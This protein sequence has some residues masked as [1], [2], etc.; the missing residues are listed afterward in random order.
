MSSVDDNY[1][2]SSD[3]ECSHHQPGGY[4]CHKDKGDSSGTT[5]V[6]CGY[7]FCGYYDNILVHGTDGPMCVWSLIKYG[8]TISYE[9]KEE[10]EEEEK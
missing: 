8:Y 2:D 6:K 3:D 10:E 9:K 7:W 4:K 5:C 1:Y